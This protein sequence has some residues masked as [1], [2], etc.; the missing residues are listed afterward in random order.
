MPYTYSTASDTSGITLTLNATLDPILLDIFSS[1]RQT[2]TSNTKILNNINLLE[3]S[4]QLSFIKKE[5]SSF[6]KGTFTPLLKGYFF[7]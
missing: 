6:L 4:I 7:S 2:Y 3:S 5:Y 1:L